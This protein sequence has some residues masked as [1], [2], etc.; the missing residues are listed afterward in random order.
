MYRDW[1]AILMNQLAKKFKLGV[2]HI[3]IPIGDKIYSDNDIDYEYV[4]KQLQNLL[5]G[6]VYGFHKI[7][8]CK[9]IGI[10]L[11]EIESMKQFIVF[12]VKYS[13]V[14]RK[15]EVKEKCIVRLKQLRRYR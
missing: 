3:R 1:K 8:Q 14:P 9:F 6:K 10:T 7:V 5:P 2:E 12:K 13:M 4:G 15:Y 11:M